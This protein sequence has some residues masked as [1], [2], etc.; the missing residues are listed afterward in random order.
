MEERS[1]RHQYEISSKPSTSGKDSIVD[2]SAN[3]RFGKYP[4]TIGNL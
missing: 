4:R 2:V 1:N 3:F